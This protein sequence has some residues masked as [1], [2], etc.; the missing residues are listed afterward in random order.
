MKFARLGAIGHETP[1]LLVDGIHYDVSSVTPDIDGAFLS[2]DGPAAVRAAFE[3]D[4]LP[5]LE[6]ADA[7]R[8]GAPIA[9]P[10][11]VICIGMNYAAHAAESGS[12]PPEIPIM[13]LKTPNTVVGPNDTVEIPRGSEKTDWEVELGIVIGKRASYLDSPEESMDHIAGFVSAN[14]VSERDFQMAVSGGQWSKGKC[15]PGFNPT[16]PWLVTPDEVDHQNLQLKSWV[17]GEIRQ[18]SNTADQIFNV[19][20]VIWHLSQ[21]LALEPGDLVLTGTPEGVALSGRFPYLAAGDV[22]EIEIEGLGRQRQQFIA[23][24]KSN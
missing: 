12:L 19:K 15:A 4:A 10:S 7:L 1:T 21:Y 24:E 8:I 2:S 23:H 3:A 5:V 18:D 16:G 13:F 11:A 6:N 22:C 9:R 14:D 20:H 17:N